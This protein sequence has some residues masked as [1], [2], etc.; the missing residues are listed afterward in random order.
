MSCLLAIGFQ[1]NKNGEI[2]LERVLNDQAFKPV[3]QPAHVYAQELAA[4]AKKLN[5]K[6]HWFIAVDRKGGPDFDIAYDMP[7]ALD[8]R[9]GTII[10]AFEQIPTSTTIEFLFYDLGTNEMRK[11]DEVTIDNMIETLCLLY[12][13]GAPLG[14]VYH[15][16][17]KN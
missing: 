17:R 5:P 16:F 12:E 15:T 3:D 4:K 14:S 10:R 1:P 8:S 6:S 13:N 11:W 9:L 7:K 2:G